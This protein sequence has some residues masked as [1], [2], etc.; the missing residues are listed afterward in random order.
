MWEYLGRF[1]HWL[2]VVVMLILPVSSVALSRGRPGRGPVDRVMI[3]AVAALQEQGVLALG[4]VEDIWQDYIALRDLKEENERLRLKVARYEEERARLLG[5][6]QENAR[7]RSLL[8]LREARPDLK[9]RPARVIGR[10]MTPWFRVLRIRLDTAQLDFEVKP[11]MA[12]VGHEGVIGQVIE[13]YDGGYADVMLVS[14]P[15]SKVDVISQRTRTRGMVHGLGHKRD[16]DARLAY[17]R[18]KDEVK[19][20]DLVV[21][22]G[23]GGIFPQELRVGQIKAVE[24]RSFGLEQQA[25]VEPS[26]DFSRLEEVFVITGERAAGFRP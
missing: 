8:E 19:E 11:Q 2:V 4:F 6:L 18:R 24:Q 5:V 12:V 3:G 23:K 9:L 13:V 20:E 1:R 21:T 7:L 26:V 10:D 15:R 22:S 25:T 17:L 14:D 16:Y